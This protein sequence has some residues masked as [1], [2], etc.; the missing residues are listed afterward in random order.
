MLNL[1]YI[2][3]RPDVAMIAESAGVGRIFVD[4]EYIG[5]AERQ[6][7]M[8]TVQSRHTLDDVQRISTALQKAEL[9]VRVNPMHEASSC[10][11]SSREEIEGA[12][13]NGAKVLMLP[14]FKTVQEVADFVGIVQGRAK[15][16]PLIETPEAVSCLDDLLFL[17][18]I[19]ELYVGL[20]DL[21]LGYGRK[22][23][24]DLLCD[25][26]V[27]NICSKIAKRGIPYG[28]GGIAALGKGLLPA[29]LIIAEHYRLGSTCAIL[30]RSFCN[31]DR[32][33]HLGDI[34]K[35]FVE[36]IKAIRQYEEQVNE[37]LRFFERNLGF[38]RVAVEKIHNQMASKQ[39]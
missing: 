35:T 31:V 9:L 4:M 38:I 28:F 5:K 26:T 22:F 8:D 19:D 27:E 37:H 10:Y 30:S 2:T 1:M 25:G 33:S 24:F 13:A 34:A 16:M 36:G 3:N 6:G 11:G 39:D 29:E 7:G 17:D 18:G 21:S 20:N 23:M 12:I 15:V 32:T 14:F